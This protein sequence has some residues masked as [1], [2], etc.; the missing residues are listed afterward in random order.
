MTN[1]QKSNA[2]LATQKS[3]FERE[4][5]SLFRTIEGLQQRA[6][7]PKNKL[8]RLVLKELADNGLDNG[9]EVTVASLHDGSYVVED[10]GAGI[11]GAPEDIA[12]LFSISRP[13]FSTKLLRL[14]T[15]G[16]LGNGLRV[17]TGTILASGGSLVVTTRNRR[18][19][20]RPERDGTT[21]VLST[22][23]VDFP[24][25]TRVEIR[26]GPALPAGHDDRFWGDLACRLAQCGTQYAGKSSR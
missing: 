23:K 24:V 14:P 4:D 19:E 3:T 20:L 12:R 15:R 18:I 6:G 13:M 22:K 1:F 2:G 11:D 7:V 21:T 5:W 9:A 26:L 25:G 10:D 17:V 8:S 16:A